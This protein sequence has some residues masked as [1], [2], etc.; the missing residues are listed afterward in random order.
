MN[1]TWQ[2][3]ASILMGFLLKNGLLLRGKV[4]CMKYRNLK[5]KFTCI[6]LYLVDSKSEVNLFS[7]ISE[8]KLCHRIIEINFVFLLLFIGVYS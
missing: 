1:E 8:F 2:K 4:Y 6:L 3:F 7:L 5:V